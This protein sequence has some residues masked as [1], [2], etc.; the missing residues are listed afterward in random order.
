MTLLIESD[1][2]RTC[3]IFIQ[4]IKMSETC[5]KLAFTYP[6]VLLKIGL[7]TNW[8]KK[9]DRVNRP[10][11]RRNNRQI[12]EVQLGLISTS[13]F[14]CCHRNQLGVTRRNQTGPETGPKL[15]LFFFSH[16][17]RTVRYRTASVHTRTE[18]YD[19]ESFQFLVHFSV[20][21]NF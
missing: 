20:P 17:N 3:S 10:L 13:T 2:N 18:R 15:D 9:L 1:G 16:E 11:K 8:M 5:Q 19:I 21:P 12:N 7:K 6:I 4:Y 14:V